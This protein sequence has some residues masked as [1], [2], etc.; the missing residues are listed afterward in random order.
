MEEFK[1]S[2]FSCA[3]CWVFSLNWYVTFSNVLNQDWILLLY[4]ILSKKKEFLRWKQRLKFFKISKVDHCKVKTNNDINEKKIYYVK[5]KISKIINIE[6]EIEKNTK[7]RISTIHVT[8]LIIIILFI[9]FFYL[10]FY[11]FSRVWL[12]PFKD[13]EK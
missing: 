12:R 4:V 8:H 10:T 1:Y 2:W 6:K 11:L 3:K 13:L 5:G 7:K 9:V